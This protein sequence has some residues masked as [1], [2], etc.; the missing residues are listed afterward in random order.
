LHSFSCLLIAPF[1]LFFQPELRINASDKRLL[2]V[3]YHPLAS[4]VLITAAADKKIALWDLEAGGAQRVTLPDAHKG[5]VSNWS[6]NYEGSLLATS[7]KD[8]K[9]R[10]FG[11]FLLIPVFFS[12]FCC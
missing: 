3:D 1:E 11:K 9:L 2:S 6:W 7:C 5:L 10:I 8:K 12:L 4:G